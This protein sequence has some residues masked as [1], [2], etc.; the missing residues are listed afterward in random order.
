[1]P[2]YRARIAVDLVYEADKP[3]SSPQLVGIANKAASAVR[4]VAVDDLDKKIEVRFD[5]ELRNQHAHHHDARGDRCRP[6]YNASGD[7]LG[8]IDE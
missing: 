1:M 5:E 3:L 2:T 4:T 7:S 8:P 6:C